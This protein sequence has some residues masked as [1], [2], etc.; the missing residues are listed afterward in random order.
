MSLPARLLR[1]LLVALKSDATRR[2][3]TDKRTAPRVGIRHPVRI[4]PAG[5]TSQPITSW[6]RN[7]SASGI[8]LLA[9]RPV[10]A[11]AEFIVPFERRDA[12]PLRVLYRATH[13]V[14]IAPDLY[15]IGGRV[16][17]VVEP[18][19]GGRANRRAAS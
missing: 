13:V 6:I 5:P 1:E 2:R 12:G 4:S 14:Q 7:L 3:A 19:S 9:R 11:G 16:V 15:T 10:A 17:C 18:I 8:G